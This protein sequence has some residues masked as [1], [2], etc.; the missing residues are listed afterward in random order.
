M[1]AG[2]IV[3]IACIDSDADYLE[4]TS[5]DN[6]A[7]EV[8][9]LFAQ[10]SHQV[11]NDL[12]VRVKKLIQDL[13]F[14]EFTGKTVEGVWDSVETDTYDSHRRENS[15]RVICEYFERDTGHWPANLPNSGAGGRVSYAVG[16]P[17]YNSPSG[18]E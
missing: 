9:K 16:L 10:V 17:G 2:C 4:S 7:V 12:F 1:D 5:M 6:L 14:Y 8:A 13:I 15:T 11:D 3:S 18:W